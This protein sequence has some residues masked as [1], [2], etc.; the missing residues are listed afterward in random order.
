MMSWLIEGRVSAVVVML[1]TLV[2]LLAFDRGSPPV[3]RRGADV[4]TAHFA[5]I[6]STFILLGIVVARFLFV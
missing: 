1:L 2:L 5:V 4:R 6:G 3:P